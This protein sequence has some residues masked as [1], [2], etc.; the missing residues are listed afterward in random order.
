MS[1]LIMSNLENF[2]NIF[3]NLAESAYNK[4]PNNFPYDELKKERENA[5]KEALPYLERAYKI[6]S[7]N[8]NVLKYLM[9]IYGQIGEDAK[10]KEAKAKLEALEAKG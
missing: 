4:R 5:Y 10:Y 2:N 3:A 7:S 8:Q 6:N 9:N 1:G